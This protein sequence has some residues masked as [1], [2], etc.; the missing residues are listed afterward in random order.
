M[1][2]ISILLG[3]LLAVGTANA[4]TSIS[5]NVV[6][7][8]GQAVPFATI[9]LDETFEGTSTDVSGSFQ[10]RPA[11]PGT[12]TL[13]VSAVSYQ[14]NKQRIELQATPVTVTVTL[15]ET[16]MELNPVTISAGAFEASAKAKA[17]MLD[18]LDIVMNAGAEGDIYKAIETLPGVSQVGEQT[19]LFVRGGDAHE[20]KTIIDGVIV[21]N[22]F[23]SEVPN[24]AS[25]SRFDPFTFQGTTFTTGG[26]SAEY[27]QA[28]SSVLLLETQDIPEV[29]STSLGLNMAGIAANR[30]RVWNDRTA[31]IGGVTYNNLW[32]LLNSVPQNFD[33]RKEPEGMGTN[34][35]FRHKSERGMFKSFIQYNQGEMGLNLRNFESISEPISFENKNRTA[36][37]NTNYKGVLSDKWMIYSGFSLNSNFEKVRFDDFQF[38]DRA[39]VGHAKTTFYY[40]FDDHS[41]LKFGIESFLEKYGNTSIV[42]TDIDDS[43]TAV[44]AE[45]DISFGKKWAIRVGGRAEYSA[46]LD[47]ANLAPRTSLAFKTSQNSQVSLAYGHF[48]QKPE[49]DF[50][51]R[52]DQLRFE[53]ATH[54]IANYQWITDDRSFRVEVYDK[55]YRQLTKES[56]QLLSNNGQG[57][58]RGVDIFWKDNKSLEGL[59]YWVSYSFIDAERDHK[60]YPVTATPPFVTD[61]TLNIVANYRIDSW[62]LTPGLTYTFASGRTYFNPNSEEFLGDRTKAY[63]NINLNASYITSLFGN[64]AV[65]YAAVGNPLGFDQVFG[66]EYSEDGSQRAPVLPASKRNFF[67]GLFVNFAG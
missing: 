54:W 13:V 25:R 30:T 35:A 18:P 8:N 62:S 42:G 63:H 6:D 41:S 45:Q 34:W 19:G 58:S 46:M 65:I 15:A 4:Q 23:F 53:R 22:P 12:Y 51:L 61:H 31:L 49:V 67:L 43:H 40:D 3:L 47:R 26:Y 28:L 38:T 56:G 9:Y 55:Q 59:D 20:T 37:W 29:T 7:K 66:Y 32:V 14:T 11:A 36:Y 64:F 24:M 50:L 60:N 57:R 44:Y 10:I 33:W 2:A 5:G 27:G 48:Y 17:T 52:Y 16:E 1:K 39:N 21:E